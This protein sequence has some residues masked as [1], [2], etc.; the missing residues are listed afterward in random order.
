[1]TNNEFQTMMMSHYMLREFQEQRKQQEAQSAEAA[2][3]SHYQHFQSEVLTYPIFSNHSCGNQNGKELLAANLDDGFC[4]RWRFFYSPNPMQLPQTNYQQQLEQDLEQLQRQLRILN[5]P[6]LILFVSTFFT[7]IFLVIRGHFLLPLVPIMAL[8][9]YWHASTLRIRQ[10]HAQLHQHHHELHGLLNQQKEMAHQLNSLPPPA[11][12]GQLTC[13]YQQAVE[14]LLRET[15]LQVLN[16]HEAN[17]IDAALTIRRWEGFMMESWGY[18]Q[19][20]LH[21]QTN[22][23]IKRLLLDDDHVMLSAM[24]DDPSGRKGH[25]VF[26][27]QY[28]HIW[29]LAQNGLL[30][31]EGYYDRVENQFLS[32]QYEFHPYLKLSHFHLAEQPLAELT[33]LKKRLPENIYQRFFQ[34]PVS[35][36]SLTTTDGK[37]YECASLPTTERPLRQSGW[38]HRYGLD[39]D[40]QQ[41]TRRL[42]ERFSTIAKTA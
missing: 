17:D 41:L 32:E 42:H 6:R 11:E 38:K 19:T 22:T 3:I 31:G 9:W 33:L 1:M 5:S 37:V 26:R 25:G 23:E 36:L 12:L 4:R 30:T 29:V 18:L 13:H 28:L 8:T 39:T 40:M 21:N 7:I 15:L 27:I 34:R 35:I 24:Q 16:P 10:T 20:P 2:N 14:Y